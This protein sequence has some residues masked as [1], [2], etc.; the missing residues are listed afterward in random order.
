MTAQTASALIEPLERAL[1]EQHQRLSLAIAPAR[2]VLGVEV[3]Y[4]PPSDAV[5]ASA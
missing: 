4:A 2:W 1:W 5:K 3:L